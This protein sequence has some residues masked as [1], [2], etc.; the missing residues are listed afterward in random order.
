MSNDVLIEKYIQLRDRQKQ[1]KAEFD[2]KVA[3]IDEAMKRIE[4]HLM[5]VLNEQGADRIGCATGVAFKSTVTSA[6]VADKDA[7]RR[8]I[9]DNNAW[10][11]ADIRAAKTAVKDFVEAHDDIPP[12]VNWRVETV[13]RV[14][15]P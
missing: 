2:E 8:F 6:T 5:C 13:L 1:L 14:N 11:L 15:R 3:P 4:N 9:L 12:G 10:E 7:F